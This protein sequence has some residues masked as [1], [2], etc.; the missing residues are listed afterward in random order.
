MNKW[1]IEEDEY[2]YKK[3]LE[4]YNKLGWFYKIITSEK[5]LN[6]KIKEA[7]KDVRLKYRAEK[8][9]YL[10]NKL[11]GERERIN[12]LIDKIN[13]DFNDFI[14]KNQGLIDSKTVPFK[15]KVRPYNGNIDYLGLET[16]TIYFEPMA[17][18]F[19]QE[20]VDDKNEI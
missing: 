6:K 13:S 10:E 19:L 18:S 12:I 2:V 17:I 15:I 1:D 9:N 16:V 8:L 4:Y 7:M 20:R 3:S 5:K 14:V 11:N